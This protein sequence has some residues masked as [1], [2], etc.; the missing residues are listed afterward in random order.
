ML[1]IWPMAA[2]FSWPLWTPAFLEVIKGLARAWDHLT[3]TRGNTSTAQQPATAYPAN[4]R[5]LPPWV[6]LLLRLA[7]GCGLA[8]VIVHFN[9]I[10][11]PFTLADN[12]HYMFYVF[13]YTI[14]RSYLLRM[15]LVPIYILCA[16]LCWMSLVPCVDFIGDRITAQGRTDCSTTM[17]QRPQAE[18]YPDPDKIQVIPFKNLEVSYLQGGA[19]AAVKPAY[20]STAILLLLATT[21][22]LM[23]APLVEPRYFIIPWVLWRLYCPAWR[24]HEH[25]YPIPCTRLANT[26]NMGWYFLLGD[27][28]DVRATMETMSLVMWNALTMAMFLYAPFLWKAEDGTVIDGGRLQRFIW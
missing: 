19:L 27:R 12:R 18:R 11:H 13:R 25:T 9:T 14:R 21:L 24:A 26:P 28:L 1:Y 8:V 5:F 6:Y 22:S 3:T 15:A 23:T 7:A 4:N 2:L 17:S 16:W 10:I 20:T